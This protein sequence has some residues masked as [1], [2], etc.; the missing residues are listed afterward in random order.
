MKYIAH[1]GVPTLKL[2]N[3]LGSFH[4]AIAHGARYVEC[5]AWCSADNELVVIHDATLE[6]TH[7]GVGRVSEHTTLV[8]MDAGIPTLQQV[9]EATG[10]ATV[11]VELKGSNISNKHMI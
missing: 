3:T 9:M 8:L 2:E 11:I 10:D 1:R 7:Q 6:R 4:E 5:D